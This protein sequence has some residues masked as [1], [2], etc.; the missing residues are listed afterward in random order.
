MKILAKKNSEDIEKEVTKTEEQQCE[1]CEKEK[2]EAEK[3]EKKSTKKPHTE[4]KEN[5]KDG[6][7][8]KKYNELVRQRGA[9]NGDDKRKR[10]CQGLKRGNCSYS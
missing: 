7:A 8:E 5:K 2:C 3:K 6:E 10:P 4:K 1:K 9:C